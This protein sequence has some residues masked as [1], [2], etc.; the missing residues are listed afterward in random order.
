MLG[1]TLSI[2]IASCNITNQFICKCNK[3]IVYN[4][5]PLAGL[6]TRAILLSGSALSSWALVEDP[7]N[8]AISLARQVNCT[9]PDNLVKDHELIVDCLREVSLEEL[10]AADIT[11]PSYLTAFGPSVDG[12]VI[13]TDYAKELLTFF[14]PN[15]MQGF[16]SVSGVNN[17]KGGNDK[18]NGDRIFG[19]KGG[20]NKYD[21]L[22]G[23]VTSEALWRFSAQD[24]Q[25]G[26]EGERRDRIIR[27]VY[28]YKH[29]HIYYIKLNYFENN[30][31]SFK[32]F[33]K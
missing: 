4:I 25:N 30:V 3:Y 31:K 21:L 17:F 29:V 8:Y 2:K 28:N 12:V 24:I 20:Q 7:V 5:I 9:I 6:F 1:E 23:V 13:K 33:L 10:M 32:I 19:I 18:R 11:A 16:T 27:Y 15:D 22:F 26:F 14:I